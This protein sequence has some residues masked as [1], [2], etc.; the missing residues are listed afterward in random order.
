MACGE[1]GPCPDMATGRAQAGGPASRTNES[2][3]LKAHERIVKALSA[4]EAVLSPSGAEAGWSRG[5]PGQVGPGPPLG[6]ALTAGSR[7]L[8][9]PEGG[10]GGQGASPRRAG[11]AR[12]GGREPMGSG[13]RPLRRGAAV[14]AAN[15]RRRLGC[16]RT[17]SGEV[18]GGRGAAN[19]EWR[20]A[21]A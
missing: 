3:A 5:C 6:W 8:L 19:G 4:R 15:G 11:R 21:H 20:C 17:W 12:G 7:R 14:R 13:R 18:E 10:L 1:V 16:A 2:C 9:P